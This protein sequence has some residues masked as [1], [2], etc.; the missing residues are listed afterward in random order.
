MSRTDALGQTYTLNGFMAYCSVNNNKV[1]AG[2]AIVSAA[3]AIVTPANISTATLTA[4]NAALSLAY[5][6]T[7]LAANTRMFLYASK[8]RSAGRNFENDYRLINVTAAAAASPNN[9]FTA[10]QS[11]LGTPVTGTCLF[12]AV[13]AYNGGFLSLPYLLRQIVA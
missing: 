9:F 13:C 7:P 12:L 10:Y 2:D 11:R 1:A 5:T 4:T 3:P 6:T 8:C